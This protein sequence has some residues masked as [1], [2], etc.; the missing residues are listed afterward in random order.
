[1]FGKIKNTTI[2]TN[3]VYFHIV[4]DRL[5]MKCKNRGIGQGSTQDIHL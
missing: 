5:G 2:T 3:P 4:E 1:M